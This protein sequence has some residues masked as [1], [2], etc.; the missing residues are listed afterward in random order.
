VP[1]AGRPGR[2]GCL[3]WPGR[4]KP[5]GRRAGRPG[6]IGGSR[7]PGQARSGWRGAGA[8]WRGPPSLDALAPQ[9]VARD[10][11]AAAAPLSGLLYAAPGAGALLISATGGWA[12]HVHRHGRAIAL[13]VCGWGL[14]IAAFGLA[15]GLW[16]AVAALAAAGAADMV[17][18]IFRMTMWNQTILARLRGRL[19]GLEMIS[20]TTGE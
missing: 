14:A 19:A 15:P 1:R 2:A 8:G 7:A 20:Y 3:A 18:G 16:P 12:G 6:S 10:D 9:L 4:R 17:S 11:L 5:A 13:A